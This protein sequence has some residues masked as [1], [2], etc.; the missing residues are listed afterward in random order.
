MGRSL[1]DLLD[2]RVGPDVHERNRRRDDPVARV[3]Q[4]KRGADLLEHAG[5]RVVLREEVALEDLDAALSRRFGEMPEEERAEPEPLGVID[6]GQGWLGDLG[7]VAVA[8]E[9]SDAQAL[10][11]PVGAHP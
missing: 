2:R 7:V 11:D 5:H 4:P 6:H 9:P 10:L 8:D 3:L 1:L